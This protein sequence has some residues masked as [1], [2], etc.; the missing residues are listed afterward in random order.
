MPASAD[1]TGGGNENDDD[2]SFIDIDKL[3][4]STQQ[5]SVPAS[6]DPSS[7]VMVKLVD[8]GTRGG[9]PTDS[10]SSMVGSSRGEHTPL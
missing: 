4:P 2:D 8:N 7:V 1:L 6:A 3:L 10:S 5:K 9:S